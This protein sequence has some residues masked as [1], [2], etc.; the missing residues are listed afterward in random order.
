[1]KRRN[2][3]PDRV[4]P[5]HLYVIAASMLLIA[6]CGVVGRSSVKA[7]Q[8]VIQGKPDVTPTIAQVVA[9]PFPQ[10]KVT[11]P[12]GGAIL[13]LGNI[14]DGRQAW[15]SAD[16]SI[17]F[18]KDGLVVATSGGTPELQ[19]MTIVG[20]SPFRELH[21][22][23]AGTRV[24][25]WY[26]VMPGYRF[27]LSVTGTLQPVG[28]ESMEILG[29][30]RELLHVREHLQGNGW[31]RDNHYWVDPADGFIWK[32]VQAIAPDTSL[33]LMQLKPYSPRRHSR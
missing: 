18:L 7:V 17:V 10:M 20:E 19:E 6:G 1:M 31:A 8:L 9:N 11:G 29:R 14:D 27:G 25:R 5:L 23:A 24:R 16:H 2:A 21:Q 13:V 3:Y 32:S 15:Y 26:D 33:E 12:N 22:V 30:T 28:S 4:V